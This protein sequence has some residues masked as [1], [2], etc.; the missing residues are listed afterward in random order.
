VRENSA[1]G[2]KDGKKGELYQGN[3]GCGAGTMLAWS[4]P[5]LNTTSPE[6][7]RILRVLKSGGKPPHSILGV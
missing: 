2:I 1:E 6:P 3:I 5:L 4:L 7:T